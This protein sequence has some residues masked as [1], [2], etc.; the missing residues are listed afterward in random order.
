MAEILKFYYPRYVELHNYV[1]ANNFNTKK[2]NWN[3]L[4]RK[5]LAKIDMK[6]NKDTIHHLANATQGAIEKLLLELKTKILKDGKELHRSKLE[7]SMEGI[8]VQISSNHVGS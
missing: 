7:C 4:N 2:E 5:V 1:P 6:L 3:T 8:N